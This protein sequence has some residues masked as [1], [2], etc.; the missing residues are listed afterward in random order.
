MDFQIGQIFEGEYPPEAAVWCN[1]HG[2]RYIEEIEAVDGQRRFQIKAV[3][4]PSI[5]ELKSMKLEELERAFLRWY[6]NDAICTS[7]LGFVVDSDSRAMMDTSGLVTAAESGARA[8][9]IFM[10]AN[11]E[12][13]EL[14]SDQVKTI[15]LEI[16]QNGQA[17]YQ[18]KWALRTQIEAAQDKSAIDAIEIEFTGI[19]FSKASE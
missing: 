12:P 10:D 11:N 15:Q 16:I 6:E 7:S 3:P 18:Q 8:N 5:E 13:H 4:E 9:V 2:D 17:A 19:D 14:T 1:D